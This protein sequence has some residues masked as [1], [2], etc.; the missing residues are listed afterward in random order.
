MERR[1]EKGDRV[2]IGT[3]N[4]PKE[5]DRKQMDT[6]ARRRYAMERRSN[7]KIDK[8]IDKMDVPAEAAAAGMPAEKRQFSPA[9]QTPKASTGGA[10]LQRVQNVIFSFKNVKE[11][12]VFLNAITKCC[13]YLH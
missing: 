3:Q 1:R 4:Q 2:K 13:S 6:K 12:N 10:S 5:R 8:Q 7:R 9:G 11:K